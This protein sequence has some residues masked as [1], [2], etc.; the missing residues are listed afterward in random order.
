MVNNVFDEIQAVD[1]V[2]NEP[3]RKVEKG[4]RVIGVLSD[5][6]LRKWYIYCLVLAESKK[7]RQDRRKYKLVRG[8]LWCSLEEVFPEVRKT[9]RLVLC[10]G[11]Q[12]IV[13]PSILD[14]FLGHELL[15]MFH[16]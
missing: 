9:D 15:G 16:T 4:D 11:W 3:T 6:F 14:L 2:A 7:N 5:D 12:V 13:I 10:K 1:L 8:L